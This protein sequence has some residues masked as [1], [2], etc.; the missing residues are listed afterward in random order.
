MQ[1]EPTW[2]LL[3]PKATKWIHN[4]WRGRDIH[5]LD[6]AN[7]AATEPST[8]RMATN[9]PRGARKVPEKR[10][11]QLYPPLR[12]TQVDVA[13]LTKE[14]GYASLDEDRRAWEK[15]R[16]P[17]FGAGTRKSGTASDEEEE[18]D[19]HPLALP[20]TVAPVKSA[21]GCGY[22]MKTRP[23]F[24]H[25]GFKKDALNAKQTF[26]QADRK[27][28]AFSNDIR[29]DVGPGSYTASDDLTANQGNR[30]GPLMRGP[31][32]R[33]A[34]ETPSS[35]PSELSY[36]SDRGALRPV[37]GAFARANRFHE[38]PSTSAFTPRPYPT[39]RW[40][41]GAASHKSSG[42]HQ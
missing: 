22:G 20:S 14:I 38:Q 15:S 30:K 29:P 2:A 4:R 8:P 35:P 25:R 11:Q 18:G 40:P 23:N 7:E 37:G 39:P 41:Q 1:D 34:V 24:Y 16:A 28:L 12:N 36:R 17:T 42:R 27:L 19:N 31:V 26:N 21:R 3:S 33:K 10:A 9:G 6:Q 32:G 5:S 13:R